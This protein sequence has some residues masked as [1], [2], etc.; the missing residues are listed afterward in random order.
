MSRHSLFSTLCAIPFGVIWSIAGAAE[1]ERVGEWPVRE[2]AA[3]YVVAGPAGVWGRFAKPQVAGQEPQTTIEDAGDGW[4]RVRMTWDLPESVPQDEVAVEFAFDLEPD[5]WWAPH[6]APEDGWCV[7]QHV[8]RSPA[9]I[10]TRQQAVLAVV[11][12]LD[13]CG[14]S[15]DTPWFLDYDAPDRRWWLGMT[16]TEL[17]THVGYRKVPGMVIPAGKLEF[18]FYICSYGDDATPLDP[19]RRVS[20]FLW[21]RWGHPLFEKGQPLT[22]PMDAYVNHTYR[23]AF[24]TW[25]GPMWHEFDIEG[26][27][28][29]GPAFIVNVTESPN[30]TGPV[31][32]REFLSIWN[33][34]WFSTLRSM[35]GVLR[36]AA[37]TGNE[38]LRRR[39]LLSKELALAAP[40][41]DGIFPS[42][43]RTEMETVT[44][45]GTEIARSKG[46]ETGYWTNSNRCPRDHGVTDRWYHV[47]DASWTCLLLLRWHD[48][49]E[50]DPRLVEYATRYAE[51]LLTLQDKD[52]FFPGW[53]HPET[54]EPAPVLAQSPETSMSVTFLLKLADVTGEE[55]YRRAAL[56]AMD[57]VIGGPL[58]EGRWEDFETY[59]SCCGFGRDHLG[60]RFERNALYKQCSFSM[61]WTAE[62]LL[63]C[64]RGTGDERYLR[65]GRRTLNELSM[66]QQVW[67]P[68]FIHIPALGGFGVMNFDGE[69]NDSRQCLFAE[70]FMDYY[71]ETG[72]PELFERGVAALKSA[73]VMMYCP[74]NRQVKRLW[75][76]VWP[77]FGRADY[78]FTMENYGHGGATGPEG[79]GVGEFTIFT[80]G[81]GA[82]A[83]A[84]NR[85]RDHFGDVYVDRKRKLGF[86]IDSVAVKVT[87][88]AVT[89]EDMAGKPRTLRVVFEDG[90]ARDVELNGKAELPLP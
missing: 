64:Y 67:Q 2:V 45:G 33:Q 48:E 51:K 47:L 37:R 16:R 24:D 57:A 13:L 89:L 10:V 49:L 82:A 18:G 59:W 90:A 44:V 14:R 60:R 87:D 6:L 74:E 27:R 19:W 11:P 50:Q 7:A 56:R 80:W 84:R 5:S 29:G 22:T 36:Y 72:E 66:V 34:A 88:T 46:W 23:W 54:L 26:R 85:I 73:F 77:F 8:F 39:A 58:P 63:A 21:Q 83:E 30:Y 76:K 25:A 75:E 70:L 42:V 43:Y 3:G 68:A 62:A 55:R 17:A 15:P 79:E 12:D 71:R 9:L 65:W 1:P 53:L 69:W 61:F 41:K 20:R 40:M 38:D 35:S 28:V 52:G 31:N 32:L 4:Q 78:G 81:N 86:G